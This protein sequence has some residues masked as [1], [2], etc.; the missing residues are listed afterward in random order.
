MAPYKENRSMNSA[1]SKLS[2]LLATLLLGVSL[3]VPSAVAAA[4]PQSFTGRVSD[5]MCGAHHMMAGDPAACTRACIEKGSKY[6]LVVG[7][8]V[9]VLDTSDQSALDKLNQLAD[10]PAKVTGQANGDTIT[11]TAVSAAK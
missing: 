5:A 1:Y 8:K 7:E 11:V 6:V 2:A 9:Y 4:K 3:A 10:K